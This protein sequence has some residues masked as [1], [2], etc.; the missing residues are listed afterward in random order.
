[1]NRTNHFLSTSR[2]HSTCSSPPICWSDDLCSLNALFGLRPKGTISFFDLLTHH[3]GYLSG[4][5]FGTFR[6]LLYL[7]TRNV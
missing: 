7:C 6:D 4:G 3:N 5:K 2:R 1:M